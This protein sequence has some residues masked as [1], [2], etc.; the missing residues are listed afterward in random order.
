MDLTAVAAAQR[1]D[2]FVAHLGGLAHRGANARPAGMGSPRLARLGGFALHA[3]IPR[4]VLNFSCFAARVLLQ[5]TGSNPGLRPSPKLN[6]G[7]ASY[8]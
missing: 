7:T 6:G 3:T 8:G 4:L 2:E 1:D 5:V